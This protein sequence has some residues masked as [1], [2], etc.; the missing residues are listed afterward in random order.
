MILGIVWGYIALNNDLSEFHKLWISPWGIIFLNLLRLLA[1]PLVVFSIIAGIISLR[2]IKRFASIAWKTM[3][4]YI[5]TTILAICIGLALGNIVQPGKMSENA[6]MEQI[7]SENIARIEQNQ[8]ESNQVKDQG[9]MRFI[10]D[11]FP[12]NL[13]MA[14][15]DNSKMLQIIVV[16]LLI[17]ITLLKI[18]EDKRSTITGFF[19]EAGHLFTKMVDIVMLAAPLGVFALMG[20]VVVDFGGK[21]TIFESLGKYA[22]TVIGGLFFILLVIYPMLVFIFTGKKPLFF[23]RGI[24]PAQ[25][26]AFTTSSSAATLPVTTRQARE[27][28]GV[29]DEVSGFVLP[30]GMTVNMDGTSLYQA[31]SALFIAQLYSIDL[32]MTDQIAILL[33]ALISSIGAPGIPGGSLVMML[34]VLSSAGIPFEGMAIVLGIDR[35][36]DMCRTVVNVTGDAAVSMIVDKLEKRKKGL[37]K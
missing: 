16:A 7:Q 17:G 20:D 1:V 28:L 9:P 2:E 6:K 34:V 27:E 5:A 21:T 15:S 14:A 3:V 36:L 4:L 18:P 37:P 23:L 13:I 35:L 33:T 22:I 12:E 11:M 25:L 30:L 29:S 32:T 31:V 24:L 10:V 26:V 8:A 19:I